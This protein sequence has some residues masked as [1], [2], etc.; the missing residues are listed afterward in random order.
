MFWDRN[1]RQMYEFL[2]SY[3]RERQREGVFGNVDPLVVVR[4]FMG[5]IIHHSVTN[6]LWD[7]SRTLLNIPNERAARDFT[8]ILLEGIGAP[9]DDKPSAAATATTATA[10]AAMAATRRVSN[11][12]NGAQAARGKKKS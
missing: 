4:A 7:K 1:M 8:R 2:G 12:R 10:A 3:I 6:T 11:R 9:G 5:M